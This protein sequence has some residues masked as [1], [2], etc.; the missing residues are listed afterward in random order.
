[1]SK[2]QTPRII[3][4]NEVVG[5]QPV[6][7]NSNDALRDLQK[8]VEEGNAEIAKY[9]QDAIAEAQKL[10]EKKNKE[11]YEAGYR[12]GLKTGAEEAKAN[13]RK[14]VEKEVAARMAS[15]QAALEQTVARLVEARDQWQ[16]EWERLGLELACA[17]AEKVVK[18]AVARPNDAALANLL[19]VLSLVG[20]VPTVT[21]HLNPADLDSLEHNRSGWSTATR[22][23]GEIKLVADPQMTAGGCRINTEFGSIDASIEKQLERIRD[24]L[25]GESGT[26]G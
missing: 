7:F 8:R 4:A 5:I 10:F 20:K 1:M 2:P 12:E 25:L 9:R 24:E 3:K 26:K 22:A 18:A 13:H 6:E 16:G 19:Q 21:V 11:G 17:I 14:E 23:I 15:L